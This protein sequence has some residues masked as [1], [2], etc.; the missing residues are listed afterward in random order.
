MNWTPV[1]EEIRIRRN[2]DL[3]DALD[4]L[5]ETE[6]QYAVKTHGEYSGMHEAYAVVREEALEAKDE[7]T[8]LLRDVRFF[9]KAVRCKCKTDIILTNVSLIRAW[10]KRLATEAIH[11]AAA[12]EKLLKAV[13]QSEEW[14]NADE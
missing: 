8:A 5:I 7:M 2:H 10:S 11:C 4:N 9:D 1:P 14:Q 6:R 12:S 13:V 3:S